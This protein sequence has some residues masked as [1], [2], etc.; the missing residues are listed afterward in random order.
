[1]S[2]EMKKENDTPE[3]N[4]QV[5]GLAEQEV[6]EVQKIFQRFLKKY[7][8]NPDKETSK[9]LFEQLKEELPE[10]EEAELHKIA[11]E[12]VE[13]INDY[14]NDL[15]DLNKSCRKGITKASWLAEKLQDGAKGVA[16]NEFGEYLRKL[17]RI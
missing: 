5:E 14:Q 8:E 17:I 1:M 6:K 11:D 2:T 7:K 13:A 10:K 16:V 15:D 3:L 4:L 12:I 9:W